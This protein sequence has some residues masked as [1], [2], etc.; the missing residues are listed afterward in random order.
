MPRR[1]E[2]PQDSS[3]HFPNHSETHPFRTPLGRN[4]TLFE[5]PLNVAL[6]EKYHE[7][8]SEVRFLGDAKSSLGDAK[9]SG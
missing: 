2:R 9:S 8:R 5:H 1:V 3:L 6:S 4:F 7:P